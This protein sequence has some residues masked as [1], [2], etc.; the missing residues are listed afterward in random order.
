MKA[1]FPLARL[2][3]A[4][5]SHTKT[6]MIRAPAAGR[7]RIRWVSE[8]RRSRSDPGAGFVSAVVVAMASLQSES[9][10]TDP[11]AGPS[12]APGSPARLCY[13]SGDPSPRGR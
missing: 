5:T 4:N 7:A 3:A 9:G 6:T 13:V 12:N 10:G 2:M 8:S 11:V 1:R